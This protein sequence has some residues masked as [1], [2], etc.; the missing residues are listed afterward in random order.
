MTA[1]GLEAKQIPV[2]A[3]FHSSIV[4]PAKAPLRRVLDGI[5]VHSPRVP[6]FSNVTGE[7]YPGDSDIIREL[8]MEQVAAP[9]EW[10]KSVREMNASGATL[11]FEIGPKWALTSFVKDI[12]KDDAVAV[13]TNHPKKG[14]IFHL[15]DAVGAAFCHGIEIDGSPIGLVPMVDLS[16]EGSPVPEGIPSI[17]SPTAGDLGTDNVAA[18][19]DVKDVS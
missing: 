7:P 10:E 17:P 18:N 19:S 14:G 11:F 5:E 8:L 16:E 9:V 12:L 6:I 3:A 2:S 13:P 4:A 15:L 1:E